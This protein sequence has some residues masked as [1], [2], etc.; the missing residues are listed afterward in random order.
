MALLP[1]TYIRFDI[2]SIHLYEGCNKDAFEIGVVSFSSPEGPSLFLLHALGAITRSQQA[3]S[4]AAHDPRC[5]EIVEP[6]NQ[7]GPSDFSRLI[8]GCLLEHL[9]L[10]GD[11]E[12]SN[13]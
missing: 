11:K 5:R 10:N 13:R 1:G 9:C 3:S 12:G 4:K 7:R 6:L 2:N 8:L